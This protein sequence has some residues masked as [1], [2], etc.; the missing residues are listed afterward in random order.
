MT[1]QIPLV[2]T[3][4]THFVWGD[5]RVT[6]YVDASN[7]QQHTV[8]DKVTSCEVSHGYRMRTITNCVGDRGSWKYGIHS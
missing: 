3:K 1:E 4:V 7:N 2:A 6:E 5:N 8:T